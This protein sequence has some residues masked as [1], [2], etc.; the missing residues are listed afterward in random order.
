MKGIVT[1]IV[2]GVCW[3]LPVYMVTG[4]SVTD[5]QWWVLAVGS[6]LACYVWSMDET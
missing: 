6:L 5:Y 4:F 1:G 3:G 2:S